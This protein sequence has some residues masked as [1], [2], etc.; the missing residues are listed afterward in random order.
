MIIKKFRKLSEIVAYFEDKKFRYAIKQS[1]RAELDT[2][3]K[4]CYT[5]YKDLIRKNLIGS[6][7]G[8]GNDKIVFEYSNDNSKVLKLFYS[9]LAFEDEK[10]NYKF[11]IKNG[12]KNLTPQMKFYDQYS[13]VEK[14]TLNHPLVR[15]ESNPL[16]LKIE[17]DPGTRN[18]GTLNGRSVLMDLGSLNYEHIKE[19]L[20]ILKKI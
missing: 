16:F 17:K 7:I 1:Y 20:E 18:F 8:Q 11:L 15:V 2:K 9:D 6:R 14:V 13:I 4:K 12:L 10:H 5:L 3:Y 19:N